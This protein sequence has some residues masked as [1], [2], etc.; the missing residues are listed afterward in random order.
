MQLLTK[1][2]HHR[3]RTIVL[4]G[5]SVRAAAADAHQA[6]YRVIGI[7]RFGDR[8]LLPLCE[9]WIEYDSEHH[10][11]AKIADSPSTPIVPV[12]GFTW[13]TDQ[14]S[15]PEIRD[16]LR[17]RLIAYPDQAALEKM[18]LPS[19]LG[20]I[21]EDSGASFPETRQLADS[22][23]EPIFQPNRPQTSKS[24]QWL[25]K[26]MRHAGGVGIR[27]ANDATRL[28]PKEY[29]QRKIKGLP[30]GA[31]YLSLPG[32]QSPIVSFLGAFG[33]LT[34][35]RNPKHRFL[36]GGSFGPLTL[37]YQVVATLKT[38]GDACAK[39]LKLVGLFNLDLVWEADGNLVL[40][41]VNPRYSASMELIRLGNLSREKSFSLIDWHLNAYEQ[42]VGDKAS[43]HRS[44]PDDC[45]LNP[46]AAFCKRIVYA[47]VKTQITKPLERPCQLPQKTSG[48]RN[49]EMLCDLPRT[50][51]IVEAGEPICTV[52]VSSATGLKHAIQQSCRLARTIRNSA[53]QMIG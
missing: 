36:Y 33:G 1:A 3:S 41:E 20:R 24:E 7:D 34:Y 31:N 53:G 44:L 5:G 25:V 29:L 27:A 47:K 18:N 40:L 16:F 32:P 8:D 45:T 52:I 28:G 50:S 17:S 49:L 2:M 26:P 21:A 6:G 23:M 19:W 35:R 13:P 12:G 11:I 22:R 4:V 15:T 46:E 48:N 38:L 10:W 9:R 30:I 42:L 43:V 39:S 51:T 37:P 14:D